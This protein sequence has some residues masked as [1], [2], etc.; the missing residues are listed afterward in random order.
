MVLVSISHDFAKELNNIIKN[1]NIKIILSGGCNSK[2]FELV[3]Q[4]KTEISGIAYGS[5]ARILASPY[6]KN[7][8]FWYNID[9]INQA[10]EKCSCLNVKHN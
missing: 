8:K 10:I 6:V 2:T 4:E 7:S 5:F 1:K 3:N 9:V